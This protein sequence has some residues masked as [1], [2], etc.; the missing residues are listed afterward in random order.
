MH[1]LFMM[2]LTNAEARVVLLC[3]LHPHDQPK[4]RWKHNQVTSNITA[5]WSLLSRTTAE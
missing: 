1:R 4:E 2:Q 3:H 5:G